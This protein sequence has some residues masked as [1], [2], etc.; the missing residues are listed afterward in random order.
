MTLSSIFLLMLAHAQTDVATHGSLPDFALYV[1]DKM[2]TGESYEG[3]LLLGVPDSLDL[4]VSIA[5]SDDAVIIPS[6]I[7]IPAG[8]NQ[9]IF[10]ITTEKHVGESVT[11]HAVASDGRHTSAT[12]SIFS[13]S[14]QYTSLSISAP[15]ENKSIHTSSRHVP[16][17]VLLTD[18]HGIPIQADRDIPVSLTSSASAVNFVVSGS[19]HDT[20]DVIIP[21][22]D[23]AVDAMARINGDGIIY[24]FSDGLIS[25]S[26]DVIYDPED[27]EVKLGIAP[28]PAVENS[29]VYYY[30]WIEQDGL[31][32]KNDEI[33]DVILSSSDSDSISFVAS[34]DDDDGRNHLIYMHDGMAFGQAYAKEPGEEIVVSA[35][36]Q[37]YGSAS[38]VIDVLEAPPDGVIIV[39][40]QEEINENEIDLDDD[41]EIITQEISPDGVTTTGYVRIEANALKGWVFPE[42]PSEKAYAVIGLYHDR[43]ISKDDRLEDHDRDLIPIY[44]TRETVL[45]TNDGG[46][47]HDEQI[48]FEGRTDGELIQ[49]RSAVVVPI[50][51]N[52]I[53]EHTLS[54]SKSETVHV[55]IEFESLPPSGWQDRLQLTSIPAIPGIQSDIAWVAVVDGA[56]GA[57]TDVGGAIDPDS[58]V[59]RQVGDAIYDLKID[60]LWTGS[61]STISGTHMGDGAQ[62]H[63]QIHGIE[64]SP[65]P[66][67]MGG[68]QT[69]VEIW[70]PDLTNTATEFPIAIHNVDDG[71]IPLRK[72][73]STDEFSI[74]KSDQITVRTGNDSL[75]FLASHDGHTKISIIT[76]EQYIASG[77][78]T[79]FS[80]QHTS[81]EVSIKSQTPDVLRL[82]SDIILDLFTDSLGKDTHVNIDGLD[83]VKGTKG[84]YVATP[85][86]EGQYSVIV[87]VNKDGWSPYQKTFDYSV[88]RLIDVTYDV[89]AD[90]GV[91]IA[92]TVDIVSADES[93]T[94][95]K[96]GLTY[97]L[98]P[99]VY[100]I[101][102]K[103][104][105][106]LSSDRVYILRDMRINGQSIPFADV[107]SE[108]L[109]QDSV[110]SAHYQREIEVEYVALP[111]LDTNGD[112]IIRGSG[113]YRYG[114]TVFL[115]AVPYQ[116]LFGMVWHVPVRWIDLPDDAV[117]DQYNARF[118]AINSASGYVE[119]ERN[120]LVVI[121]FVSLATTVPFILIRKKSPETLMNIGDLI[122]HAKEKLASVQ[123]I[124]SKM[125]KKGEKR[126]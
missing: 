59:A 58:V 60:P 124:K 5:T 1:P 68:T 7:T 106:A 77:N 32:Y 8:I 4:T 17:K 12:S 6:S 110:I 102:T 3:M 80:N 71:G 34:D 19:F 22:G 79:S 117:W 126:K 115:E 27:I 103:P 40:Y 44:W 92:A 95:L 39:R 35:Q 56:T 15:G 97:T 46:M 113:S 23:Y 31:V 24:A 28:Q 100:E 64:S 51:I 18:S 96:N 42:T 122:L 121:I 86:S 82:G 62:V 65:M 119:Y 26:I 63:V 74:P 99:D 55:D 81:S 116:E 107:F 91:S 114:D 57:I 10:P 49:R 72:I 30:V 93:K 29:V 84:T 2:I 48:S 61:V 70:F 36:V 33:L 111:D 38:T 109:Q 45:L 11:I 76:D 69:G 75:R 73:K 112:D 9:V 88:E 125:K 123:N 94:V 52:S 37:G 41:F 21:R 90:D 120:Y 20:L 47:T 13:I 16:I 54:A 78:F 108:N 43:S 89:I 104:E 25:D 50:E 66:I 98:Q 53:S 87:T 101:Y 118:E 67:E 14:S 85:E 105:Y 83:F